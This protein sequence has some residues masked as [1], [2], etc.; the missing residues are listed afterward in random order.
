M[1]CGGRLGRE[2]GLG[3]GWLEGEEGGSGG[4]GGDGGGG[5]WSSQT[6]LLW[7]NCSH[8]SWYLLTREKM[9]GE[10]VWG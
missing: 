1:V 6:L 10:I 5:V 8:C 3:G 9:E 4:G 7:Q 2:G